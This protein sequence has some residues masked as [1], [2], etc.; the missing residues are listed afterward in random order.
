MSDDRWNGDEYLNRPGHLE[1]A[2]VNARNI[3]TA[4]AA[5]GIPASTFRDLNLLE[6]G[7]GVGTVTR[8]LADFGSVHA[9]EPSG[10][11]IRVLSRLVA[12]LPNVTFAQHAL[13]PDSA[14]MFTRGQAM[15][16]PII[17]DPDRELSPPRARWDVAVSTL[18]A[19]HVDDL[20]SYFRGV[21][22]VLVEGGTFF[23]LEFAHA[24]DGE[25]LSKR[26]HCEMDSSLVPVN[27]DNYH[28]KG[29]EFRETWTVEHTK[30]LFRKYGFVD[31]GSMET[32]PV[33]A[34][35]RIDGRTAVPTKVV[36][37]H[38]AP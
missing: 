9:L 17:D 3:H 30:D 38:R 23:V 16:S 8:H 35:G 37:G 33:P 14:S 5:S 4:I 20:E 36:W 2:E 15:P 24:P 1:S 19:H 13:G 22:S 26:F 25:D 12:D 6:V 18:V 10:N 29:N 34:F 7:A 31:I 27:D 32:E 11:M 28:I 21:K